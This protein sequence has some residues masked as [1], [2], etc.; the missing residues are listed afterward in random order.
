M[1]K[2]FAWNVNVASVATMLTG[3]EPSLWPEPELPVRDGT[4]WRARF[5]H[6]WTRRLNAAVVDELIAEADRVEAHLIGFAMTS[7]PHFRGRKYRTVGMLHPG[8]LLVRR[9][10][11]WRAEDPYG[12]LGEHL[13]TYGRVLLCN[14]LHPGGVPL[15]AD[16]RGLKQEFGTLFYGP[17]QGPPKLRYRTPEEIERWRTG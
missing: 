6:D 2:D 3:V 15:G 17:P 10:T 16:V 8:V 5:G 4:S 11:P 13:R 1:S 7:N 9:G 12:T 14:Y